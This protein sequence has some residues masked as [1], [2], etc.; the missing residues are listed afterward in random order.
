MKALLTGILLAFIA[1]INNSAP[2]KK[3]INNHPVKNFEL[4]R[5]LGTWYEIARFPH[6]FEKGLTGVTATY[7]LRND[8]K[9]RVINSGYKGSLNGKFKTIEGK[10]KVANNAGEG[11]LKVSFFLFFYADYYILELDTVNYEYALVGSSSPKYLWILCRYPEM[12]EEIYVKLVEQAKKRG[13]ATENLI[14]VEQ[15]R[16]PEK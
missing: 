11:H 5:Y 8:G 2:D 16:N 3:M 12:P 7:S 6:S 10:A 13:Y 9:I 4:N 14:K 1:C 15:K